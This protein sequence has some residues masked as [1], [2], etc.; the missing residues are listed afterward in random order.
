MSPDLF[1]FTPGS[2]PLLIS[3]PH[4]GTFIPDD[5]AKRMTEAALPL[6]DTDWHVDRLYDFAASLGAGTLV[7]THSRYV[8]DLNRDPAGT[9]L[10]PGA[11]NSELV[12][13]LTFAGEAIYR[14]GAA[15]DAAEVAR[16]V[17]RFYVPYHQALAAE[18]SRLTQRFGFALLWDA[19]SIASRVPRFFSGRLPDL[20]LGSARGASAAPALVRRVMAVLEAASPFS[21]VLDGR[22][23]GGYITRHFG[24]PDRNI[25]ALQLEMAEIAY[26]DE[27]PPYAWD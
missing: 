24:R 3:F 7:A 21:A 1:R 23:T 19:H 12:P 9:P 4:V 8:V 6:P 27:A 5:L 13:L 16:R 11:Q 10:Y 20:N 18:L 22:F 25:H 15:P 17:E 2:T 26:M 14:A